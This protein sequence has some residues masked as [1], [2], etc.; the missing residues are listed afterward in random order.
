MA[1]R[2]DDRF[3]VDGEPSKKVQ[4]HQVW[5]GES[6]SVV[7]EYEDEEDLVKRYKPNLG[8]DE[9][10]LVRKTGQVPR[11]VPVRQYIEEVKARKQ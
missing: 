1:E 8:R 7:A 6:R 11:Y 3:T 10:I 9:R 4:V 5:Q 2:D